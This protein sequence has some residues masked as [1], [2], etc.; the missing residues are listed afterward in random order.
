V[1]HEKSEEWINRLWN[2]IE[3]E[4]PF[5]SIWTIHLRFKTGGQ[6]VGKVVAQKIMS[7]PGLRIEAN[8][9]D[10][11][12]HKRQI[13]PDYMEISKNEENSYI[14]FKPGVF[15]KIKNKLNRN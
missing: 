7:L 1:N 14:S 10:V 8:T 15:D 4:K 6:E 11:E 12:T 13:L 2:S 5:L 9:D 3:S